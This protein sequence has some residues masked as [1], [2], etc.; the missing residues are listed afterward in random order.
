MQ[1]G[2]GYARQAIDRDPRGYRHAA[3][4][5]TAEHYRYRQTVSIGLIA[6]DA[7][8]DPTL[9]GEERID[10]LSELKVQHAGRQ[11]VESLFLVKDLTDACTNVKPVGVV[12]AGVTVAVT[13]GRDR[14]CRQHC[15]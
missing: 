11:R 1:I 13:V 15:G 10:F 14:R 6:A 9:N 3:F 7:S 8:A 12:I 4:H 2:I 5:V